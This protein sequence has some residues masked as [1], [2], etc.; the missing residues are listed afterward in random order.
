MSRYWTAKG[1]PAEFAQAEALF[2]CAKRNIPEKAASVMMRMLNNS[3]K[4]AFSASSGIL[5]QFQTYCRLGMFNR[6]SPLGRP[7]KG[8]VR[9]APGFVL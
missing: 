4:A 5:D 3:T 9:N 6:K 2:S 7:L 8:S 1:G